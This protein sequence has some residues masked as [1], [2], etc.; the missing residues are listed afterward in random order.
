MKMRV[1]AAA[2]IFL[3]VVLVAAISHAAPSCC[4]PQNSSAPG[5]TLAPGQPTRGL[6]PATSP[7]QRVV[8]PQ[9]TPAMVRATGS[10]WGGPAPQRQYAASKPVGLPNAPAAPSCCTVPNNS[11]PARGINPA[12]QAQF[13]GCGLWRLRRGRWPS[14]VFGISAREWPR[15]V[16]L[17]STEHRSTGLPGGPSELLSN[18]RAQQQ[19]SCLERIAGYGLPR[20]VVIRILE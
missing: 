9:V 3:T 13:R 16:Y 2:S 8:N 11:G 18:D 6:I 10:N 7:Q 14:F 1:F 5:A 15:S 4:D 17:E 19:S 12:P 20:A